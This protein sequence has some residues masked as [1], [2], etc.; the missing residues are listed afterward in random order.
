M[1]LLAVHVWRLSLVVSTG[2]AAARPCPRIVC[3]RPCQTTRETYAPC[4]GHGGRC[5][6]PVTPGAHAC[7]HVSDDAAQM[8]GQVSTGDLIRV[9][10][11]AGMNPNDGSAHGW[12][13]IDIAASWAISPDG[14][15]AK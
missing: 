12:R 13:C 15:N 14:A 10:A 8:G 1:S 6:A 2:R 3:I 5:G 4:P 11:M 7:V 9:G